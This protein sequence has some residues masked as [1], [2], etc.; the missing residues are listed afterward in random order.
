MRLSEP[1]YVERTSNPKKTK[2]PY[3][4]QARVGRR[5]NE[6]QSFPTIIL[7]AAKIITLSPACALLLRL[8]WLHQYSLSIMISFLLMV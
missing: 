1:A 2:K 7:H 5:E 6:S 3:S 4:V 8:F